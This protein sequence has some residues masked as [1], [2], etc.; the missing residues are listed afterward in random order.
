MIAASPSAMRLRRLSVLH[1]SFPRIPTRLFLGGALGIDTCASRI[2]VP[3][4]PISP[5]YVARTCMGVFCLL[6][7]L[8]PSRDDARYENASSEQKFFEL[9]I[10]Y[11]GRWTNTK[12]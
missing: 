4:G 8:A 1:V 11:H 12:I 2:S 3:P 7:T 9:S 6:Q 10:R 5:S